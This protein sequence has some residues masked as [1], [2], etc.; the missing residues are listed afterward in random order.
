[1]PGRRCPSILR[2]P[3]QQGGDGPLYGEDVTTGL[4]CH[5]FLFLEDML[6]PRDWPDDLDVGGHYKTA[7]KVWETR[8][9]YV[10]TLKSVSCNRNSP[11]L[12]CNDLQF[13]SF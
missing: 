12:I 11:G 9:Q 4:F 5:E 3:S 8:F 6:S 10:Y 13:M 2:L 1:M 7:A